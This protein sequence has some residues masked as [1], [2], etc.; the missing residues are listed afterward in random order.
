[1]RRWL[2]ALLSAAGAT[3]AGCAIGP[4][5]ERPE[6]PVPAEYRGV[7][8][9]QQA[10]SVADLEWTEVFGDPEL[11]TVIETALEN[12]LDLM[13]AAARVEEFR[14]QSR[15]ARSYL[16][17]EIRGTGGTSPNPASDEDSSYSLGFSLSWEI[18][19]FGRLRRA[20]EAARAQLLASEDAARGVMNALVADVATTWFELRELD[21][22]VAIIERN[23]RSQEA[24][25]DLVQAL[26]RN[27]VASGTEE[28]QA[29]SQLASTR[30]QLP[31]AEARRIQ[32]ENRLRFLMGY[33]PD[34]VPRSSAPFEFP[35]PAEI[36]AGLPAQLLARRP[37][38]RQLENQLHAATAN[39][40]VAQASRFPYLSIGLTSFFGLLSPELARLF[41]GNDPA[42]ELFSIGPFADMPIYQSGRGTGNVEVARAQLVQSELAYR[43]GVLQA[44]RETSDALVLSDKVR[45]FI[46]QTETRV[47]AAREVQR[48]Q[49]KRYR[50]DVVSYLEVL[51]SER[52]TFQAEIELARAKLTQLQAY[53]ELYRALGGGWSQAEIDRL[54]AETK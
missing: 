31:L 16:G 40:G 9:P 25:L 42:T 18:D 6:L 29:I 43:R 48:L 30:A 15:V 8:E 45:E 35:V 53:V 52:Q 3:L 14:G 39:V 10:Q 19:L 44:Y 2:T 37:D 4:D 49:R 47:T 22:E 38:L 1:M 27:G 26:K 13:I 28:Q 21:E 7:L 11:R 34:A 20:D 33:A 51:D 32:T 46:T 24:S 5:Y 54:L 12:N 41:D 17:P 50:A 36:P 23:I